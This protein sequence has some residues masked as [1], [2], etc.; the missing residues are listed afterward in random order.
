ML[1]LLLLSFVTV[2]TGE[3]LGDKLLYTISALASRFRFVPILL[4]VGLAF[5]AKMMAAI[6]LGGF[7]A[8]LPG[9]VVAVLSS[10]TFFTMALAL[11]FKACPGADQ[12]ARESASVFRASLIS[13]SLVFFSEWGDIGQITAATLVARYH[14][15][16]V[17]WMGGTLAMI[18][19]AIL[20]VTVGAVLR[21]RLPREVLRYCGV[22]LLF[23]LGVLSLLSLAGLK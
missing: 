6:V 18:S 20:A 23:S 13:F 2:F 4:G 19:K 21:N 22:F 7:V 16:L 12:P 3:L 10:V 14:A 9:R 5:M 17:I 15:P 1:A 8:N 11:S